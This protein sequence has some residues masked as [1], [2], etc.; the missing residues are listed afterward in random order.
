M[1]AGLI[2][3]IL[4][5]VRIRRNFRL[6]HSPCG[7]LAG[8]RKRLAESIARFERRY[9]AVAGGK[10]PEHQPLMDFYGSTSAADLCRDYERLRYAPEEP[11]DD[12]LQTF[13]KQTAVFLRRMQKI[14]TSGK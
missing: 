6:R 14:K 5:G 4:L 12:D 8:N 7:G 13:R 10:R 3:C 9:A 1:A 11:S 2:A